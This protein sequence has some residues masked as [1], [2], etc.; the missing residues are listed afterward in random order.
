[1]LKVRSRRKS[2]DIKVGGGELQTEIRWTWELPA[3]DELLAPYKE[4]FASEEAEGRL[5][6]QG[7]GS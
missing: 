3:D 7:H 4:R 2:F 1:M 6:A 5:D